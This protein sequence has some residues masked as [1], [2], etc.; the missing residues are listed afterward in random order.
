[1]DF[2]EGSPYT[3][4]GLTVVLGGIAAWLTGRAVALG[5]S[6]VWLAVLYSIPL[7]GTVRFMH[8]ALFDGR[9]LNLPYLSVDFAVIVLF[10]ILAYRHT[11]TRQMTTQYGWLYVRTSPLTWRRRA[12][13][14]D[15]GP[16]P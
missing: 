14:A 8:Y 7:G 16:S 5:W 10:A 6:P 4:I 12:E 1:M 3:F 11:R 2:I 9:L 13:T 15:S